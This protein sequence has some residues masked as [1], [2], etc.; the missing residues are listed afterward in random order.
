MKRLEIGPGQ[1]PLP[2]C[3]T[4]DCVGSPTWP[5]EWGAEPLPI[6]D[7]HYA[8]VYASHVLEHVPWF[9]SLEALRE[10]WRILQPG[11]LLE[12][13]VPDF[14]A[15]VRAYLSGECGDQ[16]RRHNPEGDSMAW[17]NGRLF[18]YGPAEPNW[19]RACFDFAYLSR[20]LALAR[21]T[22]IE[23]IPK[24]TRGKSHGPA[25]LG[26]RAIKPAAG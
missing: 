23:R 20:L 7:G 11:G 18:T 9:K 26:V 14:A 5:A 4:L 1:H 10:V 21:F 6:P 12:I 19:H 25:E 15:I 13:W 8:E 22:Q 16:W 24:R 2:G 3:D 17:V